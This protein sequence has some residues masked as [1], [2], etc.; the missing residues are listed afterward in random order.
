MDIV[1]L[2][3]K[4]TFIIKYVCRRVQATSSGKAEFI[5]RKNTV[6]W[7]VSSEH[8]KDTFRART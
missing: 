7:I 8:E 5:L 1:E 3:L 6:V 4:I 2:F